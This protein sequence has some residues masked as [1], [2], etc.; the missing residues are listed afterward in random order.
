M[1]CAVKTYS[2]YYDNQI[3]IFLGESFRFSKFH[4]DE[5]K[6]DYRKFKKSLTETFKIKN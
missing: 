6:H 3:F 1:T 4:E 2:K 5:W